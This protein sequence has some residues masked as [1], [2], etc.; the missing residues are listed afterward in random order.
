MKNAFDG[1]NSRLDTTEERISEVKDM[2]IETA[3]TEKQKEKSAGKKHN[4][5]QELWDNYRKCDIYEVIPQGKQR[6]KTC[7]KQQ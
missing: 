3:K 7:L 5:I 1:L 2:T 4:R 6:E